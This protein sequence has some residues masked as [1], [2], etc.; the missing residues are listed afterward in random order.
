MI[1]F[2]RMTVVPFSCAQAGTSSFKL[3]SDDQL[4]AAARARM[5]FPKVWFS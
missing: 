2:L 5:A 3:L 1:R 4:F